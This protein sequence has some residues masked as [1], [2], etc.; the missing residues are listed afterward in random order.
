MKHLGFQQKQE[1]TIS[2]RQSDIH[3]YIYPCIPYYVHLSVHCACVWE[4]SMSVLCTGD[5]TYIRKYLDRCLLNVHIN[6]AFCMDE[7]LHMYSCM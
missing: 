6:K 1:K 4:G 5:N 2:Q 7:L 3:V